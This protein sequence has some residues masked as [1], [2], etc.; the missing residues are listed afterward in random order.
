[1][2]ILYTEYYNAFDA[3]NAN[4]HIFLFILASILFICGGTI[5][6]NLL[7][8]FDDSIP[9][10]IGLLCISI[11][12]IGFIYS[13]KLSFTNTDIIKYEFVTFTNDE[14]KTNLLEDYNIIGKKGKI[15]QI[16][17]IKK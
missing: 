10:F 9:L 8:F 14:I 4:L 12:I 5:L 7:V 2:E 11:G 1:M 17:P 16:T 3:Y 6:I 15:Y 13:F